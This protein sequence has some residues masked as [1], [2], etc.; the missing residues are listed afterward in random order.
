MGLFPRTPPCSA[1]SVHART[2]HGFAARCREQTTCHRRSSTPHRDCTGT[3]GNW[4]DFDGPCESAARNANRRG[5]PR[6][7]VRRPTSGCPARG[8]GARRDADPLAGPRERPAVMA[9]LAGDPVARARPGAFRQPRPAR[10]PSKSLWKPFTR[11]TR[12]GANGSRERQ[13]NVCSRQQSPWAC[14][15]FR[16]ASIAKSTRA[17]CSFRAKGIGTRRVAGNHWWSRPITV[18]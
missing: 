15:R 17:S 7:V 2:R 5:W 14:P 4:I 18:A 13:R 16:N 10:L 8:S 12:A 6:A 1:C 3:S 9:T 11:P